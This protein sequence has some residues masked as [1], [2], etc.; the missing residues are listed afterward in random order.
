MEG[1]SRCNERLFQKQW[2]AIPDVMK[3]YSRSNGVKPIP[4]VM[5]GYSRSNGRQFQK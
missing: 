3:G 4:D 5:K 2:K 1:Y